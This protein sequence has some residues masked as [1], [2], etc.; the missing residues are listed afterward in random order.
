MSQPSM[1]TYEFMQV[2][3]I[4][5]N[6]IKE[7]VLHEGAMSLTDYCILQKLLMLDKVT[8]LSEFRDFLL[9]KTN[10][11]SIAVSRLEQ[12]GYVSKK[13]DGRDGRKCCIEITDHGKD[14]SR[15]MSHAIRDSLLVHFW[16]SSDD[17]RINWGM[18]VDSKAFY[19]FSGDTERASAAEEEDDDFVSPSW[20]MALKYIS[21]LW[22]SVLASETDLSLNEFRVLQLL[23]VGRAPY[24]SLDIVRNLEIESS[25]VSR[26]MRSLRDAGLTE[27]TQSKKD[28]RSYLSAITQKGEE[29]YVKGRCALERETDKYYS[30]ITPSERKRLSS[31]HKAMF[32]HCNPGDDFLAS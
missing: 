4:T 14:I 32:E 11:I 28:K 29:A 21:L 18:R 23:M 19:L 30:T 3:M 26:I 5:N 22:T 7:A 13:L 24:C 16:K 10:T 27:T 17:E 15:R 9:L 12:S 6:H 1:F 2:L 31:W 8:E 20:I 25:V